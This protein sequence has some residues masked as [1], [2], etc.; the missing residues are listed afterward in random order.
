MKLSRPMRLGTASSLL[1][2]ATLAVGAAAAVPA[3]AAETG[4]RAGVLATYEMEGHPTFKAILTDPAS[5][6]SARAQLA[7]TE[8]FTTHPHGVINYSSADENTGWSWHLDDTRQAEISAEV[9][10]GTPEDVENHAI[11]SDYY[12]PWSARVIALEDI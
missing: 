4:A 8:E 7:G 3:V 11:T 5:I 10:D 1:F 9:C 2:A 6:E 12:C